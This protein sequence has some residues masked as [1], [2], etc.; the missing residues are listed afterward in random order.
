MRPVGQPKQYVV[1]PSKEEDERAHNVGE[2]ASTVQDV[3]HD[4]A[5]LSRIPCI[6]LL[7][8]V[9]DGGKD[10]IEDEKHG[11]VEALADGRGV[12]KKVRKRAD[13]I[14]ADGAGP[15]KIRLELPEDGRDDWNVAKDSEYYRRA[16]AND[17]YRDATMCTSVLVC[18]NS[19][20]VGSGVLPHAILSCHFFLDAG[21]DIPL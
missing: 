18:W 19:R 5:P 17:E 15:D 13:L 4:L 21:Q 3:G 16:E 9:I 20:G 6:R 10:D 12:S 7:G 2:G 11:N 8:N 1:A 14:R